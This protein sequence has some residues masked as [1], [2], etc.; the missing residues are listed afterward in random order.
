MNGD[1]A[2]Y[3]AQAASGALD[4]RTVHLGWIALAWLLQPLGPVA[5]DAVVAGAASV[6]AL[7]V[8]R[9]GGWRAA[10]LWALAVLPWATTAEVDV[11]WVALLL[12]AAV[13]RGWGRAVLVGAA[14]SVSPSALLALPALVIALDGDGRDI[15][16]GAAGTVVAITLIGAGDWWVGERGVLQGAHLLPGRT[17]RGALLGL[18]PVSLLVLT[19][20]GRWLALAGLP[21]LLAPPDVP[22]WLVLAGLLAPEVRTVRAWAPALILAAAPLAE[23]RWGER[24]ETVR[25]EDGAIRA[26]V[27]T[28]GPDD[29]VLATWS[30]GARASVL[31]TGQPYAL[32]WRTVDGVRDQAARWCADPPARVVLLPP[33]DCPLDLGCS[34]VDGVTSAPWPPHLL[35]PVAIHPTP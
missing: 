1:A 22:A 35:C 10:L 13:A 34:T 30:W 29:G 26:A 5:L 3:V 2:V 25:R 28:L 14:V 19:S 11:P 24:I 7:V 33:A 17:L 15:V 4:Q 31:A 16:V 9:R 32:R 27:A 6:G 20:R 12:G 21:L 23:A 18:G 8:G